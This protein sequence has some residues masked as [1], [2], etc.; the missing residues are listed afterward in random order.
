MPGD[1][2][3]PTTS[4]SEEAISTI[5]LIETWIEERI[6]SFDQ[7]RKFYRKEA[8]RFILIATG[9]SSLTTIL[10]G[11]GQIYN[12]TFISVISLVTS[13]TMSFLTAWESLYGYRQRWIQNND[14]LM[15]LYA[16]DADIQYHKARSENHLTLEEIDQFYNRYKKILQTANEKWREDR[17][18]AIN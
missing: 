18:K 1:N 2:N 11:V 9:L 16:L 4:S 14:T 3:L 7:R 5:T 17:T 13:A 8:Y 6:S 15:Q 10:I 12:L